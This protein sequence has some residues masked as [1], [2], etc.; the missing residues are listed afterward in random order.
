MFYLL[1]I[2][3]VYVV[4]LFLFAIGVT[5]IVVVNEGTEVASSE[6]NSN[7]VPWVRWLYIPTK[8]CSESASSFLGLS[9]VDLREAPCR[10]QP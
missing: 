7:Q 8:G 5:T 10:Q 9:W 2:D 3:T 1:Y 4:Y 6:A